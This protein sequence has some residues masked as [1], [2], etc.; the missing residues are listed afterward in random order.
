MSFA[1][2]KPHDARRIPG[3]G[4]T[5]AFANEFDGL[6]A[7]CARSGE[8]WTPE[9]LAADFVIPPPE[10]GVEPPLAVLCEAIVFETEQQVELAGER[11]PA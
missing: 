9:I 10:I 3:K 4:G 1:I 8:S 7:V 5:A 6:A 2:R 11:E